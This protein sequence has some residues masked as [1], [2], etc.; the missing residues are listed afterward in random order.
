MCKDTS[1]YGVIGYAW[2]GT[3]CKTSFKGYNA[4]V[5]EK[6]QNVLA[7]SEVNHYIIKAEFFLQCLTF[8]FLI[9]LWP[10]KWVITWECFMTLMKIMVV[11]EGLVTELVL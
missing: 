3:L 7:T 6:R 9:R 11:Q 10:T 8:R 5:N 4:G 1:I 2:I